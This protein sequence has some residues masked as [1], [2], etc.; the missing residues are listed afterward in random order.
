[1]R[2]SKGNNNVNMISPKT[3]TPDPYPV[4]MMPILHL[5]RS[6]IHGGIRTAVSSGFLTFS[7]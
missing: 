1:M 2:L 3:E 7:A 5:T 6:D 4:A